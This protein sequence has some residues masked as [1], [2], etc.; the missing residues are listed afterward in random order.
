MRHSTLTHLLCCTIFLLGCEVK[1]E[2][3][4]FGFVST[5]DLLPLGKSEVAQWLTWRSGKT[6]GEF[7]VVEGRTEYEYG[8]SD[9][10]QF[11]VYLNYEW[12]LADHDD[13]INGSTLPPA[14]LSNLQVGSN[15]RLD[16][17]R[18]TGGSLEAIYRILSPYIDPVGLALYLSPSIGAQ[19]REVETRVI[20]QKNFVDDRL[21]VAFNVTDTADWFDIPSAPESGDNNSP[22][23]MWNS[24]STFAFGLASTYRFTA[25]WSAGAELQ[26][27]REYSGLDPF[28]R[29]ARTNVA[30]YLGPS[31]HYAD[32]H[33][34]ATLTYLTQLPFASDYA[35]S[36]P[37]F[38]VDGR[39][40]GAG[41][42]RIRLR[43]KIG[44]FF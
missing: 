40:Y 9:R 31:L 25:G 8:L 23:R 33:M 2:E 17:T 14:T 43:F 38:D 36:H 18:F 21:V 34:Y 16:T 22:D 29:S 32:R 13:V 19:F 42:E 12:A 7:D 39:N 30:Y 27:E 44:R 4:L 10:L 1:A 24:S 11:A 6:V 26:N 3:P 37:D 41:N 28:S 20:L 35:H 5:T 15:S